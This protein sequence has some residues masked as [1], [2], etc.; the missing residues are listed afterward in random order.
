MTPPTT[1]YKNPRKEIPT[2]TQSVKQRKIEAGR[3][4]TNSGT[5]KPQRMQN[6]E[7]FLSIET[8]SQV[9]LGFPIHE[10]IASQRDKE[11]IHEICT[12][13]EFARI[14]TPSR[15]IVDFRT[16][17]RAF[18]HVSQMYYPNERLNAVP[19]NHLYFTQ[20]PT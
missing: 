7:A 1:S 18:S 15:E 17:Q 16:L 10:A 20:I 4:M 12:N 8:V 6:K 19:G 5:S 9:S 3:H 2:N 11:I 13:E 14:R